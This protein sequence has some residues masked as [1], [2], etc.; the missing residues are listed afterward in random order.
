MII[1]NPA[2]MLHP[3][4]P[5][6]RQAPMTRKRKRESDAKDDSKPAEDKDR[7]VSDSELELEFEAGPSKPDSKGTSEQPDPT[8]HDPMPPD[9]TSDSDIQDVDQMLQLSQHCNISE[10]SI[11][12]GARSHTASP[13]A[14]LDISPDPEELHDMELQYP[15]SDDPMDVDLPHPVDATKLPNGTVA[16]ESKQP[17]PQPQPGPQEHPISITDDPHSGSSMTARD[18]E[19]L[20]SANTPQTLEEQPKGDAP[21]P[22]SGRE[23]FLEYS[24]DYP[25]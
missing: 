14:P 3:P 1:E 2:N 19:E 6:T 7:T 21:Q 13:V 5:A 25:T 16:D 24:P 17:Q 12:G 11:E 23:G 8:Q 20:T 18:S 15:V 10:P 9:G 4:P 22:V